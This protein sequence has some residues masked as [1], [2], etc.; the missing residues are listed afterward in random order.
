[1][2]NLAVSRTLLVLMLL[3][4]LSGCASR[5]GQDAPPSDSA[6]IPVQATAPPPLAPTVSGPAA[7]PTATAAPTET[8]AP[9]AT[10][11]ASPAA[12]PTTAALA[13]VER[14]TATPPITPTQA[15]PAG[16]AV[17]ITGDVANLRSGPGTDFAVIG[18]ASR[19]QRYPAL[20][21]SAAGDWWQIDAAGLP[22]WVS[23]S[24]AAVEGDAAALPAAT[25]IAPEA[26]PAAA[27]QVYETTL[28]IPTY[29][30]AAFTTEATD[31]A[32]G[33]TF[34]RFDRAAYEGSNPQPV[35]VTYEAVVLENEYLKITL[36][37]ELGGRIYQV[38][39]KPT[40]S[41]ELYQNPVIKPS[42]W[43]PVEQG[44][45]L[46]AGGIEWGLPAPEHGYAWGDPWGHITT[47]FGP[48]AAG[49]T[50]FMP[51]EDHLRAE[52]D[53]ILRAGEAAFTLRPRIV[54]PTG[55][56]ASYQFWMDALL[57]P[58]PANQPGPNL[59]FVLP[60]GQVTVH[61]RG[62]DFLPAEQQAM[63]WPVYDGIDFSRLGNWR[64]WLGVFE[65][66]AAHGPFAGV[67]D[68]D[69]DE[70]MVRVFPPAATPGSKIF[71]M[72]YGAPISPAVYTDDGSAYVELHGGVTPTYWDQA[73]LA[74]GDTYTWQ[75]T[76]YPVAGIGGVSYADG[77]GAV[78]V[79]RAGDQLAVGVFPVRPVQGRMEVA[80]AGQAIVDEPV[81]ISPAQPWQ[82]SLTVSDAAAGA[83]VAVRLFDQGGAVVL[84]YA[85]SP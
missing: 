5:P 75:E 8:T 39:F 40:G 10:A 54:N 72:G 2:L 60:T 85:A 84:N 80:V 24:L 43:G 19:G 44:G 26:A 46:A 45:W 52:V 25:A 11:A 6:A 34:R 23:A 29:P 59:R 61:S 33:W 41:N 67:Y 15:A 20:A 82:R 83:R 47:P 73:T 78:H 55:Q 12:T 49:V 17:L 51:F 18:Q 38:I 4:A 58:G 3:L 62:D 32:T 68:P 31:P 14:P 50:V 22:A 53:V 7:A 81:T 64:D 37:P 13:T 21:R 70:G 56:A 69:A 48:D 74:A 71:A 9:T 30:Y 1:M 27:V 57:A 63:D 42:P 76:W 65:R 16:I 28:S 77:S 79:S 36:L 66:P 35:P